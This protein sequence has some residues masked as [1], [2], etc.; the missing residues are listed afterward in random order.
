MGRRF[1]LKV[2]S[3]TG[4]SEFSTVFSTCSPRCFSYDE[5][6]PGPGEEAAG[7]PLGGVGIDSDRHPVEMA[8][9]LAEHDRIVRGVVEAKRGYEFTTAGDSFSVAFAHVRGC[10]ARRAVAARA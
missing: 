10:R 4:E 6:M 8:G 3:G 5:R 1:Q 2:G 7:H 9:V